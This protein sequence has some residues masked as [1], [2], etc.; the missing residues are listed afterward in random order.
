[1]LRWRKSSHSNGNGG[2]SCVEVA[3][4]PDGVH[5]RNSREPEVAEL[6]FTGDEWT[7]FIAGAIAHEFDRGAPA[8]PPPFGAVQQLAE[9]LAKECGCRNPQIHAGVAR[10]RLE[11][12][13]ER[14]P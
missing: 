5:V 2:N 11:I 12:A 1:M 8:L 14:T 13:A 9:Q 3:F 4:G 6:L 10:A 7:A